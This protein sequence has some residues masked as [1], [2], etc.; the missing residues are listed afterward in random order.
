MAELL[1]TTDRTIKR[2]EAGVY[3][4]PEDKLAKYH[5]LEK[6]ASLEASPAASLTAS[7]HCP[8]SVT[9][10][11]KLSESERQPINNILKD[12]NV[13]TS[14]VETSN[15]K[16]CNDKPKNNKSKSVRVSNKVGCDACPSRKERD[17]RFVDGEVEITTSDLQRPLMASRVRVR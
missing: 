16:R 7:E 5:E 10:N 1:D 11:S 4:I 17:K 6:R 13:E 3:N 9:P 15:V 2:W 8:D 12:D 14:S